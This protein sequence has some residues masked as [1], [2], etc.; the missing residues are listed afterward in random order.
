MLESTTT[1]ADTL[2]PSVNGGTDLEQSKLNDAAVRH[3]LG[4]SVGNDDC[5]PSTTQQ[6]QRKYAEERLKRLRSDGVDQYINLNS[7]EDHNLK[8]FLED[9][10]DDGAASPVRLQD[11]A[12]FK[13]VIMGA[14]YGGLLFAAR[15][16]DSDAGFQPEDI[17]LVDTA[18]GFGGTWYWNRYPGL[19]CDIE[20][21]IY[22]P[23]LEETGYVPK[24]KYAY[25]EELREHANQIAEHWKITDRAMFR[26]ELHRCT[27]REDAA[28][29]SLEM[30]QRSPPASGQS[31]QSVTAKVS[32]DFVILVPGLLN[33]P[34][35]P[36]LP[37]LDTFRGQSFLAARWDYRVTGGSP[38]DQVLSKLRDKRVG[39][40]GTGATAVQV[41]PELAKW[42]KQ[43]YVYQR[44]PAS[45][46]V[47]GQQTTDPDKWAK[48][49]KTG[50]GAELAVEAVAMGS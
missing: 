6:V 28:E 39:I 1:P 46:D 35:L 45:V 24:H 41:V 25:G 27:W 15:L 19:M 50:P 26:T 9:P 44:T 23:L 30:T 40:I 11:G 22:M 34:K 4:A 31:V 33:R 5:S 47:R 10:W 29:W 8:Q 12:R 2:A 18:A 37:G 38:E 48:N 16:L 17:V 3:S 42:S 43:L 14:G 13:V 36:L 49:I 32:A 7:A 21:Y 20:S